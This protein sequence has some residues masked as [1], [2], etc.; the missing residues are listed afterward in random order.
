MILKKKI[1]KKQVLADG[2]YH[3]HL[4]VEQAKADLG[5]ELDEDFEFIG[6]IPS[7]TKE[8]ENFVISLGKDGDFESGLDVLDNYLVEE[9]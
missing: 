5:I 7:F 6:D 9:E 8:Q 1:T 3:Y 2:I 4:T